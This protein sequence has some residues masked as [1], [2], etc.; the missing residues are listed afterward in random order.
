MRQVLIPFQPVGDKDTRAN[1]AAVWCK[2]GCV[3]LP[4]PSDQVPWL[5]DFE[6]ELFALPTSAFRDQG[7]AFAQLVIFTENV[8]ASGWRARGGAK[9]AA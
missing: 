9:V 5:L 7:D 6:E 4:E 8:L 1:Q 2:N 3:L